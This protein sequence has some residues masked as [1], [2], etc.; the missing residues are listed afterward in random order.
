[1]NILTIISKL[2][3]K[4]FIPDNEESLALFTD[5]FNKFGISLLLLK[6]EEKFNRILNLL[7]EHSIPLQKMNGMYA[8]RIFAVPV[9]TVESII[10]K[11]FSINEIDFLK[12]YPEII[13]ELTTSLTIY[14][15]MKKYQENNINYKNE[16]GYDLEKL[17]HYEQE[18]KIDQIEDVNTYLKSI[19]EDPSL[20]DKIENQEASSE[21]EDF[22]VALELQKVENK[23][24]EDYLLP[25]DD[26]WKIV[27]N[28]KEVNTFQ[29]VKNTI[30][31]ITN[32]NLSIS[33]N[34]ALL[35]VLFY[36]SKLS[37]DEI[38]DIVQNELNKGG[39]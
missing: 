4:N 12:F 7:E 17:L 2:K 27:I 19:L 9:D 20:I 36:K 3:E 6:D 33:F 18:V 26:G 22:N 39:E 31:T 34:D 29:E 5:S 15:N 30:G 28:Q 38:D 21:E 11:Y 35:I 24:C 25:V 1:M 13:A 8:L 32:L 37:V 14:E 10:N 23:I 16:S